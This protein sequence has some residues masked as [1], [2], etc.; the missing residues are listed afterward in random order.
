[1]R[2]GYQQARAAGVLEFSQPPQAW[3]MDFHLKEK[4]AEKEI[5]A[6]IEQ[7][8]S[9]APRVRQ[10]IAEHMARLRSDP[11][12]ALYSTQDILFLLKRE[13]FPQSN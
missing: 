13:F 11:Q 1:M 3:E 7:N 6:L 5:R 8:P 4:A 9:F 10:I 12:K 2:F